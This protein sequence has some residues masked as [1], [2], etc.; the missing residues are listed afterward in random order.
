MALREGGLS[1][2]SGDV[3]APNAF[4]TFWTWVRGDYAP[5]G[6]ATGFGQLL[7]AYPPPLIDPARKLMVIFSAKSACTNVLVW[8][9][10]HLGHAKAVR[11]YHPSPHQYRT[12]VY[13]R[14]KLYHRAYRIKPERFKVIR[15]VRD[16]YERAASGFRHLLRHSHT[17][18]GRKM[19][20]SHITAN[21]LSFSE[22]LDFLE[23][24]D[25]RTCDAH[26]AIQRHPVEDVL[27]VRFLINVSTEDLYQRLN[28][29]EA[30]L[31][32]EQ[33]N[34]RGSDW[35]HAIDRRNR[36][37]T[38]SAPRADVFTQRLFP[39]QADQGPWPAYE[40]LLT[41]AVRA[42]LAKLYAVDIET[43]GIKS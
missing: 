26:F 33:T 23:G 20:M 21:G 2:G 6:A 31:G 34:L 32:L 40:D 13:Y 11:D 43:Y 12:Q 22:Y 19:G 35:I 7:W 36:P 41:P 38:H 15:V 8:F 29:V 27:P 30:A 25:L 14:S 10:H 3:G 42:R 4:A 5:P 24:L 37:K 18:F 39:A 17:R 1:A 9:F 28:D 16:P